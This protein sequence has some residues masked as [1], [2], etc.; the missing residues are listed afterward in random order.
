MFVNIMLEHSD[1]LMTL[2]TLISPSLQALN[3]M[4]KICHS[5]ADY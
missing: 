4:L 1:T 2:Y 5:F 3:Q